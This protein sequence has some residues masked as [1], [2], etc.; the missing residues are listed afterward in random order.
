MKV[1][2]RAERLPRW[3]DCVTFVVL[4]LTMVAVLL[5]AKGENAA[6]W[7][8]VRWGGL[9]ALLVFVTALRQRRSVRK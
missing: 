6:T 4:G 1:V 9:T 2:A 5:H 3:R 8:G 7:F